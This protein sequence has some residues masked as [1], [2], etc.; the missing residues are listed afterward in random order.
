MTDQQQ[1]APA[2]EVA[3]AEA[4]AAPASETTTAGAAGA[5]EAPA[6][7]GE[8]EDRWRR[9]L[10]DSDDPRKP[11]A[12]EL[13]GAQAAERAKVAAERLPVVD[14]LELALEHAG[15]DPAAVVEGVRA[16]RGQA[17]AVL[18]RL[19]FPPVEDPGAP[20]DPTRREA[21]GVAEDPEAEPGTV[22]RV[23]HPGYGP[24]DG[25]R[26]LRPAAVVVARRPEG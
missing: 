7:P 20:F 16:V 14:N 15:A 17:L 5:T 12:R 24:A 11:T 10:A 1:A 13:E 26:D 18:T 21:A 8:M 4:P 23:L 6:A 22:V 25:G 3:P 9:A 2:P 19:G